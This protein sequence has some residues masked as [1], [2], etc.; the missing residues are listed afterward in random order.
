MEME[1]LGGAN[2]WLWVWLLLLNAL[3]LFPIY[4]S[5]SL[6]YFL[7]MGFLGMAFWLGFQREGDRELSVCIENVWGR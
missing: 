1:V 6:L 2:S 4:L 3:T 5:L 7:F